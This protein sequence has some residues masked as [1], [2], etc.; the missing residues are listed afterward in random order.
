MQII[1]FTFTFRR[2]LKVTEDIFIS[3]LSNELQ[4]YP[5]CMKPVAFCTIKVYF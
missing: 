3:F 5:H 1:L 4:I 2:V